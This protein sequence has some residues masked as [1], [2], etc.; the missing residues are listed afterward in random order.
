[1]KQ[2]TFAFAIGS[3]LAAGCGMSDPSA[4]APGAQLDTLAV[5]PYPIDFPSKREA[6]VAPRAGARTVQYYGGPVIPNPKVN[7][8]WW[9]GAAKINP[10]LTAAHGGIA[11]YFTGVTNS[12]YLDWLNEYD[13]AI[14][15]QA[16]SKTGTPGTGQHIGRGNYAGSFAL[17]AVPAGNV[18][19]DQI[20]ATLSQAVDS[21][22]LPP[23]DDDTI[24][25]IF[26]PRG[27]TITL[28]GN[29]SS[30]SSF[31]AYHFAVTGRTQNLYYLVIPDCGSGFRGFSV[32]TSHELVEAMTDAVPTPGSNPDFPQA[33]NDAQGSEV[34]DLCESTSG[35]VTTPTGTF[36]VQGIWDEASGRCPIFRANTREFN[37]S[38]PQPQ[39]NVTVGAANSAVVHTATVAGAA[40]TL[41]LSLVAPHGVTATLSPTQLT[42]GQSATLTY[43]ATSA[44]SAGQI[45]VRVTGTTGS[46]TQ[47][48][49]AA[50]LVNAK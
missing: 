2:L 14:A 33:W 6:A 4:L 44:L 45:I 46:A 25:A 12:T 11:D 31:G 10:A 49:S 40:Q 38:L 39:A 5:D 28:Q 34:G 15:T 18:T 32:V 26:F 8:V 30:C 19:D 37:V 16:G 13:T 41:T 23:A 29:G 36:S 7:V 24:Y 27:V 43:S 9:G 35:R 22:T 3:F 1:M 42:S 17:T 47:V 20:Q 48:H 50:L 21:G